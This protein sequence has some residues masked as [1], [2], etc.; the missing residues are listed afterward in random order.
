MPDNDPKTPA[1][2]PPAPV[3]TPASS[4]AS[5]ANARPAWLPEGI[6]SPEALASR[7]SETTKRLS[8]VEARAKAADKWQRWG[9]PDEFE[10]NLAAR[11]AEHDRKLRAEWE[12]SQRSG[13]QPQQ[14]R[15]PFEGYELLDPH[16]Q[17]VVMYNALQEAQNMGVKQAVDGY[18]QQAQK[19]L[20]EQ[21]QRFNLLARALTARSSNPDLDLDALWKEAS[22]LATGDSTKLF[23][24]AVE[25]LTAPTRSQKEIDKAVAAAKQLWEQEQ[26]NKAQAALTGAGGGASA[27]SF[28]D[29]LT[30]RAADG[31][32]TSLRDRILKKML[33][34]GTIHPSQV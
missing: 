26:A 30:A 29:V 20:Q 32:R 21:E 15:D 34:D 5:G 24:L 12:A 19:Q 6:D 9:D 4:P 13:N 17:A 8:E 11:V 16:Q 33:A 27:A 7:Y 3:T 28:K 10:K 1:G 18:W 25:R 22:M 31:S 23:D 14:Q 2:N